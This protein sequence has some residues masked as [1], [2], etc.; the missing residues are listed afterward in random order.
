MQQPN[1]ISI[2]YFSPVYAF[3]QV[4]FPQSRHMLV[5]FHETLQHQH[6]FHFG[7]TAFEAKRN[8]RNGPIHLLQSQREELRSR[9]VT[10]SKSAKVMTTLVSKLP[11]K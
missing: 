6:F 5:P 10:D 1:N 3:E 8:F 4:Y 11:D 2:V 9:V 7:I